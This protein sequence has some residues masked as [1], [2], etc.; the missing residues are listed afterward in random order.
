MSGTT[1]PADSFVL[2]ELEFEGANRCFDQTYTAPGEA[3]S[4]A[5]I[6]S[7]CDKIYQY[8]VSHCMNEESSGQIR[9]LTRR[10]LMSWG[11]LVKK[12]KRYDPTNAF[13]LM[14][15]NNLLQATIQCAVFK[16]TTRD[17]FIDRKE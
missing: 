3:V 4:E 7:L 11:F 1:R 8:A 17:I 2:K 14:T 10:N 5:E 9:R 16:G 13:V 15:H 12:E 6:N